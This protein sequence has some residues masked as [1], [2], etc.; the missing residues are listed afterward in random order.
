MPENGFMTLNIPIQKSRTGSLSTRTT[1]PAFVL[2]FLDLCR[3]LGLNVSVRNP[4]LTQSK[5][6]MLRGLSP[7]LASVMKRSVS[8]SRPGRYND[9]HVRHC[10]YCVPCILRRIALMEA[11]LDSSSDYAFDVFGNLGTMD[12]AKQQ[13]MRALARFAMELANADPARLELRVL[14]HG[15][16]PPDVGLMIGM[17]PTSDYAPW[18]NMLRGWATDFLAKL[19]D[20]PTRTRQ[21]VGL[22]G[23]GAA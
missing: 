20:T 2:Q 8:C 22:P 9:R 5:T 16:F 15:Y 14:S 17:D 10:G 3:S 1:H 19:A 21:V 11:G 12:S 7:A 13:D 23:G 4:F 6:D 18:T